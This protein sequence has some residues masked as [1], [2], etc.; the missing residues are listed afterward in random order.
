[1]L[2]TREYGFMSTAA[3]MIVNIG[4]AGSIFFLSGFIM[5]F[6]G[7]SGSKIIS[8]VASLFLAAIAVMM[9]RKGLTVFI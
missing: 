4:I 3:A 8:K 5:R 9:V 7:V 6:L 1:M 2:L